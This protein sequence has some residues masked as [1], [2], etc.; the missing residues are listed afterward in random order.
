[1]LSPESPE[2]PSSVWMVEFECFAAVTD[3]LPVMICGTNVAVIANMV[4]W[5]SFAKD[6]CGSKSYLCSSYDLGSTS[7]CSFLEETRRM[8]YG[9]MD[10]FCRHSI[11]FVS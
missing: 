10:I 8:C 5:K 4:F 2:I 7:C 11:K 6:V 1:M 3:L 9:D